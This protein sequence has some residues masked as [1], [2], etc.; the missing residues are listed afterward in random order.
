M[1]TWFGL[2]LNWCLICLFAWVVFRLI[3][4][5]WFALLCFAAG[6][7]WWLVDVHKLDCLLFGLSLVLVCFGSDFLLDLGW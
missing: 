2:G 7:L 1:F 3:R 5:L 6:V 4:F